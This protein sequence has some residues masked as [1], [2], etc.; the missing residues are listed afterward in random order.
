MP[1]ITASDVVA[2]LSMLV[3]LS[4]VIVGPIASMR[5]ARRQIVSPIRQKWIDDL[6]DLISTLLS[7]CRSA[8]IMTEG[9]G[10]L[11][12]RKPNEQVLNEVLFLEQK[13]QLMLNPRESDHEELL[14]L[15]SKIVD[16]VQNGAPNLL[17]FGKQLE[18]ASSTSKAI[19]KREWERVK[20]GER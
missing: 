12:K 10:L 7:R 4:A 6:R 17:E 14:A 1:Q 16:S 9:N 8:I 3:A 15:V 13:L 5:L 11:N 2:C 19:L 20:R 18:N